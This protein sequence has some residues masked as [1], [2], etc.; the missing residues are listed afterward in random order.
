MGREIRM[1]KKGWEHPKNDDGKYQPM[2]N[3]FYEDE[4]NE[5]WENHLLWLQGKHPDQPQD[6][7]YYAEWHGDPPDIAYYIQ[8]KW[9][10]EKDEMW[11][12][13]YENVSEGTPLSPSFKTKE[14]L[15]NYLVDNGDFWG[16]SWTENQAKK[17]LE[18]KYCCSGIIINS[19]IYQNQE[20]FDIK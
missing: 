17:M 10:E 15:I 20:Q 3:M 14:E 1:V 18:N 2:F 12:C 11:F 8:E 13:L 7:K 9:D 4:L 5:W 6:Y 19:K 16:Y